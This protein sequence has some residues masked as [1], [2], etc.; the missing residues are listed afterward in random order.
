[1]TLHQ[2]VLLSLGNLHNHLPKRAL[3]LKEIL[4]NRNPPSFFGLH[5]SSQPTRWSLFFSLRP[6]QRKSLYN[7]S[8]LYVIGTLKIERKK[9]GINDKHDCTR[10]FPPPKDIKAFFHP[11][12]WHKI[13]SNSRSQKEATP[14][15]PPQRKT[16]VG[17]RPIKNR[18]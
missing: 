1:M 13:L 9:V 17:K 5:T 18:K 7:L 2:K 8:I 12:N 14:G 16:Q 6:N 15:L 4:H 10:V 11:S 3:F